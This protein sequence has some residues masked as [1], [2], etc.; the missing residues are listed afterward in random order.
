[1]L[2]NIKLIYNREWVEYLPGH[3]LIKHLNEKKV[4]LLPFIIISIAIIIT[5][6]YYGTYYSAS[7]SLPCNTLSECVLSYTTGMFNGYTETLSGLSFGNAYENVAWAVMILFALPAVAIFTGYERYLKLGV[8][9]MI[10]SQAI[11]FII[12]PTLILPHLTSTPAFGG[13]L[14]LFCTF[15]L[16]LI[17]TFFLLYFYKVEKR[18]GTVDNRA[19]FLKLTALPLA[20]FT[21]TLYSVLSISN[22]LSYSTNQTEALILSVALEVVILFALLGYAFFFIYR[23]LKRNAKRYN[24]NP[25]TLTARIVI[26]CLLIGVTLSILLVSY[27]LPFVIFYKGLTIKGVLNPHNISLPIFALVTFVLLKIKLPSHTS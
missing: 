9:S 11:F 15:G 7:K 2:S 26:F 23:P 22:I 4:Y 13:G 24:I 1:L 5:S 16:I 27:L 10:I 12:Y 20:I 19:S 21:E 25:K 8:V 6:Y 18:N 17:V 14:S 3:K